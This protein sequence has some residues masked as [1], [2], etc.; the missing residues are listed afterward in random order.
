[1]PLV[2]CGRGENVK[3]GSGEGWKREGEGKS[4]DRTVEMERWEREGPLWA[5]DV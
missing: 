2:V 1:M 4:S 3:G 5:L